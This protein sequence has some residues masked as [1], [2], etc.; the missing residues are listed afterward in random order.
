[1]NL[2]FTNRYIVAI[3][4][5]TFGVVLLYTSA[6]Q[7][8]DPW[9]DPTGG[10]P[11]HNYCVQ[12][13]GSCFGNNCTA[14]SDGDASWRTCGNTTFLAC[15]EIQPRTRGFCQNYNPSTITCYSGF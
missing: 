14:C 6:V 8:D 10:S 11:V 5:L 3:V 1:M 4:L 15:K 13:S 2:S 12:Q 9:P 7:A